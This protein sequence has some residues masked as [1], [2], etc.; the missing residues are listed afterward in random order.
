VPP[1]PPLPVPLLRLR[2]LRCHFGGVR[3]VDGVSLDV[4]EGSV[5]GLIGPNGAGKTTLV[6]LFTG[7][8]RA[9]AGS[10]HLGD[11]DLTGRPPHA[12][13]ATGVA[14]TFQA[15]RLYGGLTALENVLVGMHASRAHDTLQQLALVPALR[16]AQRARVDHGRALLHKVGLEP[17]TYADRQAATLAYGDQ[18]RLEIARALALEPRLLVLDEPA[19]GMNPAEKARVRDLLEDLHQGGLTVV[20]IDHDMPLVMSVCDR[21]AVLDFGRKIAEGT[22]SEISSH[23]DVLAAYLGV[24][25]EAAPAP[26]PVQAA[27]AAAPAPAPAPATAPAPDPAPDPAPAPTPVPAPS[28][29]GAAAPSATPARP[30]LEVSGLE[31]SYGAIRALTGVSFSV[32]EG[33]MV[34]LVGANGAGKSTVLNTL[35]GLVR[36]RSGTAVCDGID[37]TTASPARIVASG[38]VQVPEGR[39]VLARLTVRENL[40]LGAWTRRD[41]RAATADIDRFEE[42]FPILGQRRHNPAGQLS[43]GEQQVLAIARALVARPRLL[44]LD[45]PSLGLAPL[46]VE[47]IFETIADIHGGG[48]TVLLVEQ[49]AYRA[50]GLADRAY[51]M[52]AGRITLAGTG[53]ALRRD[54]GVQ[55][56]Y[57]GG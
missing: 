19:A 10:V 49:N 8:L 12:V 52:E 40:E 55:R 18:R 35:S 30:L 48:V 36:P 45:E 13:A 56:A 16:R 14:R 3:A 31:V 54:P 5:F 42:R 28:D 51:V 27:P 34:A 20:L 11:A 9:Q 23:P 53:E 17:G 37:L 15:V 24:G 47:R 39:E 22:P 6:N 41:R 1:L 21:I 44:L 46:L 26:A 4:E 2:D 50:L 43:G 38:V 32:G 33:E 57:L 25:A 29:G 7:F